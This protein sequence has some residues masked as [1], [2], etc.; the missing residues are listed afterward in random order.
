[1][2]LAIIGWLALLIS[3]IVITLSAVIVIANCG[4]EFN[5]GGQ[6]NS[7]TA[8]IASAV[9]AVAVA[10]AWYALLKYNPFSITVN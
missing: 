4:G 5:I 7:R 9:L 3:L 10:M 8:K 6:P 2:I 1:M